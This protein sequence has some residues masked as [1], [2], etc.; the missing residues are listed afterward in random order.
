MALADRPRHQQ[1]LLL[2]WSDVTACDIGRWSL[3]AL[4]RVGDRL[5]TRLLCLQA[6]RRFERVEG[7]E[8]ILPLYDAFV[9]VADHGSQREAV[10]LP[11]LLIL[12]RQGR[13][14]RFLADWNFR[15]IPG[16]GYLYDDSG[17]ITVTRKDA[18]PRVLNRLKSLFVQ[19]VRAYE[20]AY[21]QLAAEAGWCPARDPLR[22]A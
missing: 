11:A 14:V 16:A 17:A 12:A 2:H 19:P 21:R 1:P 4:S 7:R 5:L 22:Q 15:L 10:L 8:R 3:G 13:P 9:L 18:P 6:R 20:Q